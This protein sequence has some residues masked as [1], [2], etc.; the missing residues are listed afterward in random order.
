V[1]SKNLIVYGDQLTSVAS[2]LSAMAGELSTQSATWHASVTPA[3]SQFAIGYWG[4]AELLR[5]AVNRAHAGVRQFA[6][7]LTD[8]HE[9][10]AGKLRTSMNNYLDA[11]HDNVAVIR[12]ANTGDHKAIAAELKNAAKGERGKGTR[13][14]AD[15]KIWQDVQVR[16][17][18][19]DKGSVASYNHAQIQAFLQS[20][21]PD[22]IETAGKAH[23]KLSE[24]LGSV[25]DQLVGHAQT[26]ADNWSGETAV[27]AVGYLQKLHQTA[28][29]LQ[30]KT[31]AVGKALSDYA[32]VLKHYQS[33]MPPGPAI[34]AAPQLPQGTS[35]SAASTAW[36]TYNQQVTANASLADQVAQ[37]HLAELNGHIETTYFK[38]PAEVRKN[39]PTVPA[40]P[41]SRSS[42][43]PRSAG[44]AAPAVP[45]QPSAPAPAQGSGGVSG[46][47][48]VPGPTSATHAGS[49]PGGTRL[50]GLPGTGTLISPSPLSPAAPGTAVP[51]G[52][53]PGGLV[54][55][56]TGAG[57]GAGGW[58]DSRDGVVG[59]GGWG[60]SPGPV[61]GTGINP[62]ATQAT[63]GDGG[64]ETAGT[65]A[66]EGGSSGEGMA[67]VPMGGGAGAGP[68][69]QD[70]VRQ[71][72]ELEDPDTW[73]DSA[74]EPWAGQITGFGSDGVISA[75]AV[76]GNTAG[77]A[78]INPANTSPPEPLPMA[79][80][81]TAEEAGIAELGSPAPTEQQ[82]A[83]LH[84]AG[85]DAP[86]TWGDDSDNVK[87]VIG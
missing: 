33:T 32:P 36:Q 76:A 58:G 31:W 19:F 25:T 15:E 82:N 74:E 51:P 56:G 52:G 63:G 10:A 9:Q 44:S 14:D 28:S 39:L 54:L 70:R 55:P 4:A 42:Q 86:S 79:A 80:K 11:E 69:G 24:H 47:A 37:Q 67:G 71:V 13:I 23:K 84:Q 30:E 68:A 59:A 21:Q 5:D 43:A 20:T 41:V 81:I 46:P 48:P 1:G 7:D 65:A 6:Q 61:S 73:K 38:M 3:D 17:D 35:R 27:R 53:A 78:V 62:L 87:P 45:G 2:Q 50:A 16:S 85:K 18:H 40:S 60:D 72:W 8:C 75:Q 12:K 34:V 66:A 77:P 57:V 22:L 64:T 26:L 29:D 49:V 83:D